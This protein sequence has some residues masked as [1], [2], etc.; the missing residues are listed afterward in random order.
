MTSLIVTP[1]ESL[2]PVPS[3]WRTLS[4]CSRTTAKEAWWTTLMLP[5]SWRDPMILLF[6]RTLALEL[7]LIS[8]ATPLFLTAQSNSRLKV[9]F[10][11]E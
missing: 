3:N 7:A 4:P 6:H 1:N 11:A 5:I 2:I 9:N 10:F 8:E